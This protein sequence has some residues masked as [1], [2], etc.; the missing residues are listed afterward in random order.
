[1]TPE[2]RE[3]IEGEIRALK[4]LL[5]DT[6]YNSNKLIE[7]LVDHMSSATP[8]NFIDEFVAWLKATL[9]QYGEVAQNRAAWR[10]TIN[11]LEAMLTE[12]VD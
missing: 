8:E 12:E 1:M 11:E 7:G 10:A 4:S 2:Q 5:V 9:A 6:D 3:Q